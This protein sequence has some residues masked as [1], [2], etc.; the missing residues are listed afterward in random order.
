MIHV[1]A[2]WERDQPIVWWH[3]FIEPRLWQRFLQLLQHLPLYSGV[4]VSPEHE[5]G[6]FRLGVLPSLQESL[7]SM[8]GRALES[9]AGLSDREVGALMTLLQEW[10]RRWS[11]LKVRRFLVQTPTGT[12]VIGDRPLFMGVL[13]LTPDSFYDGGRYHSV[14]RA[15]KR[16]LALYEEGA[17]IIDLGAQSTRPGSTEVPPD[18]EWKRLEP[19]LRAI[20]PVLPIPISVDTYYARVADLALQAGA[21]IIN[22]VTAGTYDHDMFRVARYHGVPMVLMHFYER[23]RPMPRRP[24]Y[25]HVSREIATFL[26]RRLEAAVE[27]GIKIEQT[28]LDPGVGFGKKPEDNLE[29]IHHLGLM[30]SLGRPILF[31]PS[32]KSFMAGAHAG[33]PDERLE[34]TLVACAW[35]WRAGAHIFRV[36]DVWPVRKALAVWTA[37]HHRRYAEDMPWQRRGRP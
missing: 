14:D 1:L 7:F 6:T 23:I 17:D 13:N 31:G 16:A 32:R 21:D 27:A 37:I 24:R 2:E 3:F 34:G 10:Q 22:D 9:P 29:L 5:E 15:V 8:I 26:T 33:G 11:S 30:R 18:E 19:V 25:K 12:L 36:H 28:I 4:T 20:R 35:A